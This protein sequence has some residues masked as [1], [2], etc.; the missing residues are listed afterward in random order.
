MKSRSKRATNR[1]R[2]PP[3]PL[4]P[5]LP[6]PINE[7][8]ERRGGRKA[9]RFV[10]RYDSHPIPGLSAREASPSTDPAMPEV[11]VAG[12]R[13]LLSCFAVPIVSDDFTALPDRSSG[14]STESSFW[15]RLRRRS[16]TVPLEAIASDQIQREDAPRE[17]S[18]AMN[19][20]QRLLQKLRK[21]QKT[22]KP[23]TKPLAQK[24]SPSWAHMR[25]VHQTSS[26]CHVSTMSDCR[27]QPPARL[28]RVRDP[29]QNGTPS[30]H[31]GSPQP[32][33]TGGS[34][35]SDARPTRRPESVAALIMLMTTLA[36]TLFCG[37][38]CAVFYTCF[39]YYFLPYFLKARRSPAPAPE[40][41]G[42]N[43]D[44]DFDS[45]EYKKKVVL[46]GL[47]ERDHRSWLSGIS[48]NLS[49]SPSISR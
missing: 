10:H 4:L 9:L 34:N 25:T 33:R 39:W 46:M 27:T 32:V 8:I 49:E 5:S 43:G 2:L 18:P 15:S 44:V 20:H 47:L 36:A 26:I 48:A 14:R 28:N 38:L 35:Q 1:I 12:R 22:G 21:D 24:S 17:A 31:P 16:K 30:N 3:V 41:S 13:R 42:G 6:L 37:R 29:V 45:V 40:M 19:R 23:T 11:S 7:F